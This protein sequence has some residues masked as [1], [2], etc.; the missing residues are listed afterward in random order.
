M[1]FVRFPLLARLLASPTPWVCI[2]L[3]TVAGCGPSCDCLTPATATVTG[4]IT[5][6]TGTAIA[7]ATILGYLALPGAACSAGVEGGLTTTNAA[8]RYT[9]GMAFGVTTDSVCAFVRV[10]PPAGSAFRDTLVG[11]FRLAFRYTP[12]IDSAVVDV[13]LAP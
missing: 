7:G 3:A 8:G 1:R 10:R 13:A 5:T 6:T 9:L 12:P 4:R 11:P 2:G